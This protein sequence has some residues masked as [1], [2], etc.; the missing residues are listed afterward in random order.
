MKTHKSRIAFR[1][2][3]PLGA[4]FVAVGLVVGLSCSTQAG[5]PVD[6]NASPASGEKAMPTNEGGGSTDVR[7]LYLEWQSLRQMNWIIR[8]RLSE[9]RFAA[10]SA[11]GCDTGGKPKTQI[12][13]QGKQLVIEAE[14]SWAS[15]GLVVELDGPTKGTIE[16]EVSDPYVRDRL[17]RRTF[18]LGV[19]RGRPE[20]IEITSKEWP[21]SHTF[22][23]VTGESKPVEHGK[24]ILD[25]LGDDRA[26]CVA[27]LLRLARE[28]R[29]TPAGAKLLLRAAGACCGGCNHGPLKP[30]GWDRAIP[31]Y[32]QVMD[33][34]PGTED[35]MNARWA[36][37]FCHGTWNAAEG[38]G[39][40]GCD[41]TN[42]GKGDWAKA[43]E[44][45]DALFQAS[46]DE[47]SKVAALR[48]KA[49]LQCTYAQNLPGGLATYR[50]IM[51]AFPGQVKLSPYWSYRTCGAKWGTDDLAKDVARL[52]LRGTRDG[53]EARRLYERVFAGAAANPH[54]D[55]LAA[56]LGPLRG[57]PVDRNTSPASMEKPMTPAAARETPGKAT[58]DYSKLA[59]KGDEH[60]K[61]SFSLTVQA[62]ARVY[63][64]DV[65]YETVYALSGSGF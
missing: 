48:R 55:A 52:L 42:T 46:P 43:T 17:T 61:D 44:L 36:H 22:L 38:T 27:A 7:R 37:A 30:D 56:L 34:Y 64:I 49:E 2:S 25:A 54:I 26:G 20:Q 3:M 18:D 28:H 10:V 5:G 63:G 4:A 59:L 60:A 39:V 35:A 57:G 9:A 21:I 15:G 14:T 1:L 31:I 12:T 53:E 47:G 19:L 58:P 16:F 11:A 8:A 32:Q 51:E 45:F 6:K 23:R 40:D 24:Q 29:G 41:S 65:D 50:R 62:V 33:Q 13:D